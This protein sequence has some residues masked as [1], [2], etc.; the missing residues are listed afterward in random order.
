MQAVRNG[1]IGKDR[2]GNSFW[3][4][5]QDFSILHILCKPT[6]SS[7][8]DDG[9]SSSLGEAMVEGGREGTWRM[10]ST[11]KQFRQLIHVLSIST[12]IDDRV[13]T[14]ML[15]TYAAML[16]S[17]FSLDCATLNLF[18]THALVSL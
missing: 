1:A 10:V 6:A 16:A 9:D 17:I 13:L 12:N 11:V 3:F 2:H 5:G 14:Y 7:T 15:K 4:F 18:S 8:E